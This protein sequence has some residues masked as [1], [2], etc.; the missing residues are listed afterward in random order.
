MPGLAKLAS[1][2]YPVGPNTDRRGKRAGVLFI[3][4]AIGRAGQRYQRL[5]LYYIAERSDV[6]CANHHMYIAR[7][8]LNTDRAMR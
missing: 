3:A 8:L 1:M 6:S 2:P 7:R 5:A 4:K